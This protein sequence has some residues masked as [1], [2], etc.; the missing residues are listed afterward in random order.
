FYCYAETATG[1]LYYWGR[2]KGGVLGNGI[3]GASSGIS[4]EYPSSW[5]IPV[6][7]AVDPFALGSPVLSTSPYCLLHPE[8][9]PC[10]EFRIPTNK[11]PVAQAG[12]DREISLPVNS[13][14]VDGAA[15]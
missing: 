2:N 10:N 8:G 13:V 1:Q 3:V 5:D 15:S 7:T 4:A 9:S 12:A 14:V 6:V 11:L